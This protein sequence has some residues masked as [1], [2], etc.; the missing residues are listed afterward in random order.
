MNTYTDGQLIVVQAIFTSFQTGAPINPTGVQLKYDITV[1]FVT[2]P[3]III[4]AG[5]TKPAS[6][7]FQWNIDTTGKPGYYVYEYIA[8]GTGQSIG[9]GSFQV[10]SRPI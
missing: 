1:N 6:N 10:D 3:P 9:T 7:I 8:T 4:G 2:S 5:F